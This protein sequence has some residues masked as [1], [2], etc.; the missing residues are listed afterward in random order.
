MLCGEDFTRRSSAERHRNN[1]HHGKSLAVRFVEYLAGR[2]SGLYSKPIDPPRLSRRGRVQFG[3]AEKSDRQISATAS[4]TA[5]A[6]STTKDFWWEFGKDTTNDN[7]QSE[8]M[9]PL[10]SNQSNNA[11]RDPIDESIRNAHKLLQFKLM[12]RLSIQSIPFYLPIVD[13][14]MS[15]S[16]PVGFRGELCDTCLLGKIDP[17]FSLDRLESLVMTDHTCNSQDLSKIRNMAHI[18]NVRSRFHEFFCTDDQ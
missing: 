12:N 17:I 3:K 9:P 8:N 7:D 6:D 15:I 10:L 13:A 1:V 11:S 5:V 16:K 4:E 2:A 14:S 18:P